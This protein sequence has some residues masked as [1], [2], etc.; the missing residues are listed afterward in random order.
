MGDSRANFN[1]GMRKIIHEG[2]EDH[3]VKT[4]AST[5]LAFFATL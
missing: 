4:N 1:K 5:R 3:E 2:H